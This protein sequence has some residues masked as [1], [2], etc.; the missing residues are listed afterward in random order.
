MTTYGVLGVGSLGRAVVTGL[1]DDGGEPARVVLSPRGA[2]NAAALAAAHG[3]VSVADDNQAVLDAADVVLLF[4]RSADAPLLSDLGW[5]EEHV[6]V[7][8]MAGLPVAALRAAVAPAGR[9]ARAVP[10][11]GVAERAWATP[12]RPPL[13]E[14]M[15]LFERCGGAIAVETDDQF[16]AIYT[17]LGTVAPFF[18]YLATIEG[19]L[20]DRGLPAADAR[21][22]LA[23]SFSTVGDQLAAGGADFEAMV[24][25]HAPKGGGNEMLAG[26]MREAG[27]LT[28]TREALEGVLR[29]QTGVAED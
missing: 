22:L 23:S 26:L 24:A 13:P 1:M 18:E 19:F 2:D 11:V 16:D 4:L 14:V 21:R 8:A 5:R 29:R 27:V 10:M 20:T 28:A 25:A 6:V 15:E 7:S 3:S 17:S 12:V 9:V